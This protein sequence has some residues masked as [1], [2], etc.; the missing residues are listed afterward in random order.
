MTSKN[1]GTSPHS[2]VRRV[3]RFSI[4][5]T[6]SCQADKPPADPHLRIC[7]IEDETHYVRGWEGRKRAS[8]SCFRSMFC[9]PASEKTWW[10]RARAGQDDHSGGKRATRGEG[11]GRL[12]DGHGRGERS[13]LQ[14]LFKLADGSLLTA[15]GAQAQNQKKKQLLFKVL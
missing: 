14:L 9:C 3:R 13:G 12:D 2:S 4:F 10:H 6:C 7:S 5:C 8:N 11:E 1:E 15:Y